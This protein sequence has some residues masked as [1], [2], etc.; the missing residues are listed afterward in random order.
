MSKGY[1]VSR[2]VSKV[3][4]LSPAYQKHDGDSEL[5]RSARAARFIVRVEVCV[6]LGDDRALL[7]KLRVA[8][9]E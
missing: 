3:C 2:F 9:N 7:E 6:E 5:S 8:V 4:M 1:H